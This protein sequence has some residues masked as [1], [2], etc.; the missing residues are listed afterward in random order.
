M[1][2]KPLQ[3]A[4][5]VTLNNTGPAAPGGRKYNGERYP[6]TTNR[7]NTFHSGPVR[8]GNPWTKEEDER[9]RAA[10]GEEMEGSTPQWGVIAQAVGSARD[11]KQC[12]ERWVSHLSPSLQTGPWT[13][14]EDRLIAT[15]VAELGTKWKEIAARLLGRSEL[16]VKNR[17]HSTRRTQ[18]RDEARSSKAAAA[19][20]AAAAGA[21]GSA[22]S[23]ATTQL[24]PAA[25][26]AEAMQAVAVGCGNDV[27][28]GF[29]PIPRR[30]A[31]AC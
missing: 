4:M 10:V 8:R 9:L 28:R 1:P 15:G 19:A 30:A 23:V 14:E 31:A 21:D 6:G 20:A 2:A 5:P 22:L 13:A 26:I 11:G 25:A 29:E 24:P 7:V 27:R 18:A 3:W 17:H 16:A 12:R